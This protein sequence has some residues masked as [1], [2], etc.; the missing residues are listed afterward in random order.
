MIRRGMVCCG[1][2]QFAAGID[3]RESHISTDVEAVPEQEARVQQDERQAEG[4]EPQVTRA[5][6]LRPAD[7]PD[8]EFLRRLRA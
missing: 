2:R 6:R 7:P 8:R 1:R 5:S 3:D 4:A